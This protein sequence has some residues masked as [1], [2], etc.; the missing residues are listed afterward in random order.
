MNKKKEITKVAKRKT[1]EQ[2]EE[3]RPKKFKFDKIATF[4]EEER[5]RR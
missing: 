3:I 4:E 1:E 5:V 2:T